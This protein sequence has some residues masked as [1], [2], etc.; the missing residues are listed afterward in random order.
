MIG[1]QGGPKMA[2][3]RQQQQQTK[4]MSV[5]EYL[6]ESIGVSKVF[7][8][9]PSKLLLI[10]PT[11]VAAASASAAVVADEEEKVDAFAD[12]ASVVALLDRVVA[13]ELRAEL[14]L[15]RKRKMF[16]DIA[17]NSKRVCGKNKSLSSMVFS[18]EMGELIALILSY[19]TGATVVVVDDVNVRVHGNC[20]DG[21][22]AVVVFK[23][24]ADGVAEPP[25]A[26]ESFSQLRAELI[27]HV[28]RNFEHLS[29]ARIDSLRTYA[30]H[31]GIGDRLAAMKKA[32]M[33][34]SLIDFSRRR[35]KRPAEFV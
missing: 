33:C 30:Q 26:L 13:G 7:A 11:R 21:G 29:R 31:F 6:Q 24:G 18:P 32:E 17:A 19:K 34:E 12:T 3:F 20:C 35:M 1:V 28:G 14:G 9:F 27:D 25:I 10:K 15:Q 5:I 8:C 23:R 22:G 4:A 2:R 16:E